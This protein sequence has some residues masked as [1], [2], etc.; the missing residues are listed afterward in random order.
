MREGII[1]FLGL[2]GG[3]PARMR[4]ALVVSFVT[5]ICASSPYDR[6]KTPVAHWRVVNIKRSNSR[7]IKCILSFC[8]RVFYEQRKESGVKGKK[9]EQGIN[10]EIFPCIVLYIM[11]VGQT[12]VKLCCH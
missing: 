9:T 3:K 4:A 1:R 2:K 5:S 11:V 10:E 12:V 6:P 8:L 7:F